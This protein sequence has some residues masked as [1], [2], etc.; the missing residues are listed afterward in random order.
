[1]SN[2]GRKI[3]VSTMKNEAPYLIEWIAYHRLIGFDDFVLFSNDCTDGT[4]LMLNRLDQL[5]I[6]HHFDN[7]IG[8]GMDPQ[9]AAYSR[10]GK[11]DLTRDADWVLIIDA[12]EFMNIR[13]GD[14]HVDDL[15][16]ACE[17][18]DAISLN[19]RLMGSAGQ[20]QMRPEPVTE[21]FT[22]GCTLDKPENG[23]VWGFKTIFRPK[24]FDYFGV[25][26]PKFYKDRE[27]TA[28][29]ATW[30]NGSGRD[31]GDA[32]HVNGWRTNASQVGYAFGQINHYAVKSREEFLLKRLRG[33]ANSKNKDRI[34][35]SYWPKF[36]LNAFE[37]TSIRTEGLQQEMDRLLEDPILNALQHAALDSARRTIDYQLQDPQW[38]TFVETGAFE[39]VEQELPPPPKDNPENV[40]FLGI[41]THHKTGTIWMRK[42]FR[43]VADDLQVPTMQCYRKKRLSDLPS[44]G[45]AVLLNWHTTFPEELVQRQDTRFIHIIRDPRDILL[46]GMR[47]H[48]TA[49]LGNEKFLREKRD[50]WGGL[51]YQDFLNALPDDLARLE[52]EMRHKHHDTVQEMLEWSYD[53]PHAA[54]LRYEDLINDTDCSLFRKTLEDL[55]VEGLDIDKIVDIYWQNSLFG[56]LAAEENRED[57]VARHIKSGKA[58][59]WVTKLPR[60]IAEI[61]VQEYGDALKK[62][63]YAKDDSWVDLCAPWKDLAA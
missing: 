50:E 48:R 44:E 15:L 9:R 49:G 51:N 53:N 16:D 40:R 36:D 57:I 47:Y 33:T 61:Y 29:M 63:G 60:E 18:A 5:G 43:Q 3:V 58:A 10:A 6:V 4:N 45:P 13:V 11:M 25:H 1:M 8:P 20:T 30:F 62:L 42:V 55:G 34:D 32:L 56:G 12:D 2:H 31:L 19:W 54:E 21:R 35:T 7:P 24:V 22:R 59:Q 52:F 41:G 37:D 17:G 28:D 26:R 27:V 46:S 38:A 14:G 23:L 39:E